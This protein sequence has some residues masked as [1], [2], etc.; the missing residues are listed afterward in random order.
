[1]PNYSY[2]GFIEVT[3]K[4]QKSPLSGQ[5]NRSSGNYLFTAQ[6]FAQCKQVKWSCPEGIKFNVM[7]DKKAASDPV[8]LK[9]VYNGKITD[10]P[11]G[12]G[13]YIANPQGANAEFEIS[14]K[15]VD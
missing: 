11:E 4:S 7:K 6:S 5:K 3:M 13:I 14:V 15:K 12:E 1:M 10:L 9:D 8:I 2:E